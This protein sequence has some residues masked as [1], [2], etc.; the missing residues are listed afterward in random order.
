MVDMAIASPRPSWLSGLPQTRFSGL[1]RPQALA[2]LLLTLVAILVLLG[3]GTAHHAPASAP[4]ASMGDMAMYGRIVERM[5]GGEGYYPAAHA[6]LV[7]GDYGTRSVFNWR[8][9]TLFFLVSRLPSVLWAQIGLG[10]AAIGAALLAFRLMDETAGRATALLLVVI[11]TLSLAAC[12]APGAVLFAEVP[13]GVLIL[14]S[15]LAY[16]LGRPGWGLLAA[17][18]ALFLRELAAPYILVSIWLAWRQGRRRELVAW[19]L[20]LAAYGAYFLWHAGMVQAQLGPA[21]VAYP[22]GW[23]QWGG[24]GFMLSTA[25]FNGLLVAQPIWVTAIVLPLSLVGLAGWRGP[26]ASRIGLTVGAYLLLFL[27][28]GKPFNTYW[29][30]LYTPL[31]MFGLAQFPAAAR[32]LVAGIRSPG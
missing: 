6:E 7:A 24:L 30:A 23:V 1:R 25:A 15:A 5:Q 26:M 29:G 9:P 18:A 19:A 12:A 21:D 16:G 31:L 17:V 14:L 13:A 22:E 3:V 27:V 32:D 8:L 4:T 11:L 28:I 10:I 2:S 20:A